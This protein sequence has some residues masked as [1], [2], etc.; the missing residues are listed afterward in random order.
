MTV[1]EED[2][3][4]SMSSEGSWRV[5]KVKKLINM[6]TLVLLYTRGFLH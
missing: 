5:E 4:D 6:L 1:R 3:D 2:V